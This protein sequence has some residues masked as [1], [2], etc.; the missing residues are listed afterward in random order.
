MSIRRILSSARPT[1]R[2]GNK[3]WDGG[4]KLLA[5]PFPTNRPAYNGNRLCFLGTGRLWQ[6]REKKKKKN[7][8]GGGRTSSS[9]A[10][11]RVRMTKK[12]APPGEGEKTSTPFGQSLTHPLHEEKKVRFSSSPSAFRHQEKGPGRSRGP[13]PPQGGKKKKG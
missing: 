9:P 2:R 10:G 8:R 5:V 7:P 11:A 4:K 13:G 1:R 3:P 12:K 6:G